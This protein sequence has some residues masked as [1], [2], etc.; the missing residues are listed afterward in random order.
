MLS[1]PSSRR[2]ADPALLEPLTVAVTRASAAILALSSAP[3]GVR[4]KADLSPVTAAD[5]AAEAVI[6]ADLTAVL[7][8]IPVVSE[9]AAGGR[10]YES[11]PSPFVLV[12]PLDGTKEFIAGRA[13]FTVNLALVV[14]GRPLIGIVA[15]P[16]LRLLWRGIVGQG[17]ERLVLEQDKAV[18][19]TAI[20]TRAAPARG[21]V[22]AVSRSHLDPATEAFVDRLPIAERMMLGS[23]LK[24]CFIAEG[25]AD[26]YP[27][28]SPT[29]EW[30]IAAG[31]AVLT[32]AGGT[33]AAPDGGTISY[34]R[35]REAFRVPAFVA[36]GDAAAARRLA[37]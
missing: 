20:R 16:A 24:F 34:G 13:E 22:V 30:D 1:D 28:L 11:L 15:A 18:E 8:G 21:L 6:L 9:E 37:A 14:D 33:V 17:A 29:C 2:F 7:P 32:A 19:A 12:D 35:G 4:T 31:H 10:T 36:W 26:L 27:R 23:A 5:E 25:K 3:Q